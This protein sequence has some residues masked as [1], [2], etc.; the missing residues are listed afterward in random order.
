MRKTLKNIILTFVAILTLGV[1]GCNLFNKQV[2]Y[3]AHGMSI[4]MDKGFKEKE[5]LSATY[6]L[7]RNDSIMLAIKEEFQLL[8][9]AT[10]TLEDYTN[11]VLQ[12]N[13]IYSNVNSRENE[14][15]MYFS[16]EKM[17]SGKNYYYLATTHKAEDSFWLIQF[18]CSKNEKD[19]FE[20]KFF[21]WADT[22]AFTTEE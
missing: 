17:V 8:L 3:S 16:Y 1:A 19:E 10:L 2:T 21:K 6:Y 22:I 11:L 9:P 14:N 18:A 20:D 15:Y 4:T 13:I 12:N 7:E 5:L